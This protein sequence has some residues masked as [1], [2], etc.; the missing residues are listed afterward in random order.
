MSICALCDDVMKNA[1]RNQVLIYF[2]RH[3][4]I[5]KVAT[6]IRDLCME[7]SSGRQILEENFP[8]QQELSNKAREAKVCRYIPLAY[9][10]VC[11]HTYVCMYLG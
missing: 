4:Y 6:D 9:V 3:E 2:H 7:H 1:G 5:L 10:H 8:S 11:I